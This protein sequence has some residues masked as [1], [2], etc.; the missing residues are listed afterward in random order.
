MSFAMETLQV[1]G[2]FR[3]KAISRGQDPELVINLTK[4][5]RR[6]EFTESVVLLTHCLHGLK[7]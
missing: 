6:D 1:I 2:A 3:F 7:A 4:C 5:S